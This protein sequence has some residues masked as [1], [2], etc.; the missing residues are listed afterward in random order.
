M[1]GMWFQI[2]F[3]GPVRL[4]QVVLDTPTHQG[5]YPRAYDVGLSSDGTAFTSVA[6]GAGATNSANSLAINFSGT[7]GRYL[8][9]AS[10]ATDGLWWSIDELRVVCTPP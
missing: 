10:T 4:S 3:G 9:I 8:R 1:P 6:K 2:D 7:V 5:D